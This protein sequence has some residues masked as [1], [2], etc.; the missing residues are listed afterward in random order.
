M[1]IGYLVLPFFWAPTYSYFN[2]RLGVFFYIT[3]IVFLSTFRVPRTLSCFF[4][5]ASFYQC[6]FLADINYKNSNDIGELNKVASH[7][8]KNKPFL[9]IYF[10]KRSNHIDSFF[11]SSLYNHL[12]H[13]IPTIKKGSI[14]PTLF[15]NPLLPVQSKNLEKLPQLKNL[16][17]NFFRLILQK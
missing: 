3:F 13:Y 7:I 6:Y 15:V 14:T 4:I 8:P 12:H 16:H 2:T 9:P 11:Y 1:L 5:L 17:P 10:N